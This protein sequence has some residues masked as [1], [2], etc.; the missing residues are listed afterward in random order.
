[1]HSVL[2]AHVLTPVAL[3]LCALQASGQ[4]PAATTDAINRRLIDAKDE[5]LKEMESA[6][7]ELSD[8]IEAALSNAMVEG[9]FDQAKRLTL[10]KEAFEKQFLLPS[11]GPLG[12]AKTEHHRRFIEAKQAVETTFDDVVSELTKQ[13]DLSRAELLLKEKEGWKAMVA[14]RKT[15]KTRYKSPIA[16]GAVRW[17][18]NGHYY[19]KVDIRGQSLGIAWPAAKAKCEE[20]GGYLACGET[21]DELEFLKSLSVG[22]WTGAYKEKSGTWVWLTGTKVGTPPRGDGKDFGFAKTDAQG[23]LAVPEHGLR[24]V[25]TWEF[26]C[27]WDE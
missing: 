16:S 4:V 7:S 9:D 11:D 2:I 3:L 21:E 22:A 10:V 19:Q 12:L 25:R 5:F 23:L 15:N 13:G 14:K 18:K 1:M 20:M 26:I 6:D 27:E 24:S 8:A 17:A